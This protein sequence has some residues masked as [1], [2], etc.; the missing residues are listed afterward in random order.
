[1]EVSQARQKDPSLCPEGSASGEASSKRAE[2]LACLDYSKALDIICNLAAWMEV[3]YRAPQEV[4][5]VG[6]PERIG[7]DFD[8]G[9]QASIGH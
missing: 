5:V 1:M 4:E 6:K 8:S 3:H 7:R 2:S 9:R